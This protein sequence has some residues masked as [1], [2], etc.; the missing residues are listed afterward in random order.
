VK[1]PTPAI[2][3]LH[4]KARLTWPAVEWGLEAY[5]A[6][7]AGKPLAHAPDL[8][9]AGAAGHRLEAAW[10]AISNALGPEVQRVLRRQPIADFDVEDLWSEALARAMAD[11]PEARPLPDGRQPARIVRYRGLISL[12]NYLIVIARRCAIDS[13]R[14]IAPTLSLSPDDEH[15]GLEL[16]DRSA[17][18]PDATLEEQETAQAMTRALGEAYGLL[19][20]EQQFLL[21]MVFRQ[22]MKQK[23]AGALLGWTECKTSRALSAALD[24]LRA[25]LRELSGAA[26][27][28][29]LAAAWA[30]WVGNWGR[31]GQDSP[32]RPSEESENRE[33]P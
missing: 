15:S 17:G 4:A 32:D 1:K 9:L 12:R 30:E 19:S 8:Y 13:H 6:F 5:A 24:S 28:P 7:L 18:G 25:A 11:D 23:E 10:V 16:A 14:R 20:A 33:R 22:G 31:S 2:R 27:T 26:W 21:A 3:A 29:A